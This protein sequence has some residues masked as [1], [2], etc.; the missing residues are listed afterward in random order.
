VPGVI[1]D[2]AQFVPLTA[3]SF[4]SEGAP[5]IPVD[6]AHPLPTIT[7]APIV[8][9]MPLAGETSASGTFGPFV[10]DRGIAIWL[11][12]SGTWTGSAELLRSVD[13][14]ATRLPLTVAGQPWANF[15]G[16]ANEPVGEESSPD[17]SYWLAVTIASGTLAYRVSQ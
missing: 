6:A 2:P 11:S 9:S 1:E 7:A 3:L 13:G 4:G 15:T 8:S 16:A 14:G 5:A 17:A 10:P 12:L